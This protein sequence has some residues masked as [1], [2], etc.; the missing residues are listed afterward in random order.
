MHYAVMVTFTLENATREDAHRHI[1]EWVKENTS[2]GEWEE[3]EENPDERQQTAGPGVI[4]GDWA[5]VGG[6]WS[7]R[8]SPVT[9]NERWQAE[10]AR[11]LDHFA[12]LCNDPFAKSGYGYSD[13]TGRRAKP[14]LDAL[15]KELGGEYEAERDPYR[16]DHY[17]D[18]AILVDQR[19]YDDYLM[20]FVRKNE[21]ERRST[22]KGDSYSDPPSWVDAD[23]LTDLSEEAIVG[24]K[25]LAIVDV[26]T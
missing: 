6:R 18:D 24:K 25:W 2:E 11:I 5:V 15:W 7:G 3:D 12:A 20:L 16:S 17:L 21:S 23:G 4:D 14:Q 26:H 13:E 10:Q 1:N 19:V 22:A 9:M 8:L